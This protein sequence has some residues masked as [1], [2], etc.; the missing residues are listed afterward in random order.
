MGALERKLFMLRFTHKETFVCLFVVFFWLLLFGLFFGGGGDEG[1][2]LFSP[3]SD[4]ENTPPP[5]RLF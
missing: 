1:K 5:L 3:F 4:L 2:G